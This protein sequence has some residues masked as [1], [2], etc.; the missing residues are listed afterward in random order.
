MG[1]NIN[2]KWVL[3]SAEFDVINIRPFRKIHGQFLWIYTY[4][5]WILCDMM[6]V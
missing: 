6:N 4:N 2:L 1:K 3:C 5:L